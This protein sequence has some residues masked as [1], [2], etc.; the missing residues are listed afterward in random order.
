MTA[1]LGSSDVLVVDTRERVQ[2][3]VLNS[4]QNWWPNLATDSDLWGLEPGENDVSLTLV[5][6]DSNT[7]VQLDYQPRFLTA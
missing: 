6:T 4:S 7:T 3:A 1:S 5:G 2:T